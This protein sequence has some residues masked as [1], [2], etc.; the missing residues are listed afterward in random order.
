MEEILKK[1]L[2]GEILTKSEIE[3]VL[4]EFMSDKVVPKQAS[5]LLIAMSKRNE[6]AEEMSNFASVMRNKGKRVKLKS[7]GGLLDV[8]GT[9][10]DKT[11]T[12][13]ISSVVSL[14]AAGAG[15]KVIKHGNRSIS[16]KSGS[17]DVLAEL[18]ISINLPTEKLQ[19]TLDNIGM[20]FLFAPDYHP[21]MKY[22]K[23][24]RKNI[25]TPTIFNLLGP[26]IN[27]ANVDY[28]VI[29][30]YDKTKCEMMAQALNHL[31]IK[32]AMVVY[33]EGGLD[34][35][36]TIG[37]TTIYHL[38]HGTITKEFIKPEDFGIKR[39]KL[40]DLQGADAKENA[41]IILEILQGAKGAKRDI[42]LLNSAAAL[43]VSNIAKDFEEG[44]K[45]ASESIDS[46]AAMKVLEKLKNVS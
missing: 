35:I 7:S 44:I 37:E 13:N 15:A 34:E 43:I 42:V 45:K 8:C 28:Q 11:G 14:V 41:K 16:S 12:F 27:P 29:G 2:N 39:A 30:V 3:K 32:E 17:A 5:I 9:G 6:T 33:G 40:E 19:Q 25:D 21:S 26:L 1:T 22:I 46:G 24:I 31:G 10:G 18:G 4:D 23:T 20:V 36:S 38:K